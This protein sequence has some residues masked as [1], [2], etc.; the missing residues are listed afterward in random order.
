MREI[1]L[2]PY[3]SLKHLTLISMELLKELMHQL[4]Q[5]LVKK[6]TSHYV[7]TQI[8][9]LDLQELRSRL[10]YYLRGQ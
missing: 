5:S 4:Q 8:M 6:T 9:V 7:Q 3:E 1:N 10:I 2:G